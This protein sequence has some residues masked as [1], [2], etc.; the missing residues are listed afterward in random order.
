M[1]LR[2]TFSSSKYNPKP[3]P[4]KQPVKLQRRLQT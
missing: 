3:K 1:N 2:D 4:T